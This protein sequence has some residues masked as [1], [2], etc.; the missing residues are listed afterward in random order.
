M[1]MSS[2]WS[3]PFRFSNQNIVFFLISLHAT[4]PTHL[5]LFGLITLIIFGEVYKL[6]SS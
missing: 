4:C 1:P 6:W 3:L 5:I 2:K